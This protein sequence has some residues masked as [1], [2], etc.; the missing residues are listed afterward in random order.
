MYI[1]NV[2]LYI[3]RAHVAE[4]IAATRENQAHSLQ[5]PGMVSFEF[6]QHEKDETRFLL[7]EKYLYREATAEHMQTEHY[8]KWITLVRPWFLQPVDRTLYQTV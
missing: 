1:K 2:V 3:D 4:F 7:H 6:F 5:E 8:Q